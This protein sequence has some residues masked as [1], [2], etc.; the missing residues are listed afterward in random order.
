MTCCDSGGFASA[1]TMRRLRPL[2]GV[3]ALDAAG[4]VVVLVV[5]QKGD[6]CVNG[7]AWIVEVVVVVVVA[8]FV[9]VTDGCRAFFVVVVTGAS[10]S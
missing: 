8:L 3:V 7:V 6:D 5:F 1:S 10:F 4:V 9:F 2:L